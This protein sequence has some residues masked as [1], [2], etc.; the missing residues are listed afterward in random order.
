MGH[1]TRSMPLIR[2]LL[3]LGCT[4]VFAGNEAQRMII[5]KTFPRLETIH[6]K[7]YDVSYS[8]NRHFFTPHLICQMPRLASIV[9]QEHQWLQYAIKKHAIDGVISDNRYGLYHKAIPSVIMTHQLRIQTGMGGLANDIIQQLH[10]RFL[11]RFQQVWVVDVPEN[12]GLSGELAHPTT[13][14]RNTVYI[15]L[16]S[17]LPLAERHEETANNGSIVVLLSGP[18]P[19]RTMLQDVLWRQIAALQMPVTF[20]A[21]SVRA[22]V[23]YSIP[24]HVRFFTQLS[25]D[26][27]YPILK[28]AQV[29]VCRSGYSTLMDLAALGKRAILV[30]TAGQTEQEYL[31]KL[32]AKKEG[33]VAV[34]ETEMN[35]SAAIAHNIKAGQPTVYPREAF[36]LHE[37]V[38]QA[39]ISA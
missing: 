13:L 32:L 18:E 7:G 38:L 9:R 17:H 24:S 10:Y 15:G 33:F 11:N 2:H 21:G 35:L 31:A 39:W 14:P 8:R 6:L 27:L 25:G 28:Y 29:V 23:P 26:D 3:T 16:L 37:Q 12:Q 19:K 22:V 30:P 36:T 5:K 20:I 34:S 4:P 1:T